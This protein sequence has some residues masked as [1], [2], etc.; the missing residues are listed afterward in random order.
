MSEFPLYTSLKKGLP[1]KDLTAKQKDDFIRKVSTLD[2]PGKELVYIL[3]CNHS[4][5]TSDNE[6]PDIFPY[7]GLEASNKINFDFS[8]FP[9]D[10]RQ[11]LYKFVLMHLKNMEE[12]RIR[13]LQQSSPKIADQVI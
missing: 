11:M 6:E 1:K 10:L 8:K 12:E 9:I 4:C 5:Q 7:G 3:I 13:V 2:D